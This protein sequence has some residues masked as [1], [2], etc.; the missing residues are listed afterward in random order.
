MKK[1][2]I[3]ENFRGKKKMVIIFIVFIAIFAFII[4]SGD[5]K[6]DYL[7]N[8]HNGQGTE[9]TGIFSGSETETDI[10]FSA[11][12]IADME[13]EN[14]EKTFWFYGDIKKNWEQIGLLPDNQYTYYTY[15]DG[16]ESVNAYGYYQMDSE[17]ELTLGYGGEYVKGEIKDGKLL[18]FNKEYTQIKDSYI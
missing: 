7:N 18:I 5:V 9:T 6:S 2:D 13:A 8:E 12:E 10:T 11:E 4:M 3:K 17:T 15:S 16:K 14:A 1:F